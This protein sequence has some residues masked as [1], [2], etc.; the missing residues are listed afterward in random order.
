MQAYNFN[1]VEGLRGPVGLEL[2][3][4]VGRQTEADEFV[5]LDVLRDLVVNLSSLEI[6]IGV[7]HRH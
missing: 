1:V 4:L 5:V 2:C 6:I 7:L 3:D